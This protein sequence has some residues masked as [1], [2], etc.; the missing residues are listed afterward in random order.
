[1]EKW[2]GIKDSTITYADDFIKLE[3]INCI[4]ARSIGPDTSV[5]STHK[6]VKEHRAINLK[7]KI[8]VAVKEGQRGV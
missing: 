8:E 4:W 1:L 7:K 5:L 6:H 2:R 3:A